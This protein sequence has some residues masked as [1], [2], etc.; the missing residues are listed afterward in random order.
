MGTKELLDAGQLS[1]AIAQ[2]SQEIRSAP[3]DVQRRTF[4]FEL[5]CFAGDYQRAARQLDVIGHQ[6]TTAEV[7]VQVYRNV[8]TAEAARQ[9]LFTEGLRPDFL[10]DLPPY[11]LWHL[12]AINRLRESQPVEAE[13]LLAQAA[14]SR[15]PLQGQ[16]DGIP[17]SDFRDGDDLLAPFLEVIVHNRY[18]W[19]P[20][21]QVKHLRISSP[22]QL[23]DLLWIPATLEGQPG[24]VGEVFLPVLYARSHT[25]TDD[26]VKL[27]RMT[28]WL[29]VGAGLMRGVGQRLFFSDGQDRAILEVQEL[30]F[31]ATAPA[32]G[33]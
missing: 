10:F 16:L 1:A 2:L 26:Q 33:Q 14:A 18:V 27:G 22:K 30:T 31:T 29:D 9:Q 11:V 3:T 7:G 5:L 23:R 32:E 4:L 21:E 28:D 15:S 24:P 8:L 6:S 20:F 17:F 12:Q 25:H 13:A 19:I